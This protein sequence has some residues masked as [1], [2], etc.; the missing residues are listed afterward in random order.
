MV[1]ADPEVHFSVLGFFGRAGL[2]EKVQV[3]SPVTD[4]DRVTVPPA[5]GKEVGSAP[6][7]PMDAEEAPASVT[8]AVALAV[9]V[10]LATSVKV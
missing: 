7:D 6:K 3:L 5:W 10:P 8:M 9:F 1:E 4:V 2:E